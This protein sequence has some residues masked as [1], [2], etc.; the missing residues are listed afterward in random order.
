[1]ICMTHKVILVTII[2][3]EFR[4]KHKKVIVIRVNVDLIRKRNKHNAKNH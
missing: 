1:M 3:K 2:T 4:V